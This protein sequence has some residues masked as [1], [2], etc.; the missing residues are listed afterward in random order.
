MRITNNGSLKLLHEGPFAVLANVLTRAASAW[1]QLL[2]LVDTDI[3]KC[4]IFG[5]SPTADALGLA[6]EQSRFNFD[7]LAHAQQALEDNIYLVEAS[8][9]RPNRIKLAYY[10]AREFAGFEK[11]IL[12]L[13]A[14]Q[15][16]AMGGGNSV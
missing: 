3:D 10:S 7:Y 12:N 4:K 11:Q 5:S 2:N 14:T 15:D 6:M 1:T 16:D 9:Q 8:V 13:L